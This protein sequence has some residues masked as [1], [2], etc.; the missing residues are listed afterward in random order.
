MMQQK[1]NLELGRS[2]ATL[3]SGREPGQQAHDHVTT[4]RGYRARRSVLRPRDEHPRPG[5][6][7]TET[8]TGT[9]VQGEFLVNGRR[10]DRHRSRA[11]AHRPAGGNKNTDG[12]QARYHGHRD[13]RR[14][15]RHARRSWPAA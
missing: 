12:L 1:I 5:L 7:R 14:R 15:D 6:Y 13:H 8:A 10:G 3:D 4:V 9:D 11:D 2:T